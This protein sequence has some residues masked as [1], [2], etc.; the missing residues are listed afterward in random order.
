MRRLTYTVQITPGEDRGYIAKVPT[1][2]GCVTFGETYPEAVAMAEEAIRTCVE[3]LIKDH[4]P[5]P[6]EVEP[7][8]QV[9]VTVEVDAP[10]RA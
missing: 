10:A 4:E 5:I 1:L 7:A 8:H 9:A 6:L 3:G 2:P